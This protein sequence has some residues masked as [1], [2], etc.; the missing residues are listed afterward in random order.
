MPHKSLISIVDDDE[1][2]RE[3]MS[4]LMK[5]LGF[6]AETFASAQSFLGSDRAQSTGCLIADVQMPGMTGIELHSHLCAVGC[7]IPTV[8]ITAYPDDATRTRARKAGIIGYLTKPFRVDDLLQCIRTALGQNKQ[9][10]TAH[11]A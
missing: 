6:S 10:T 11:D 5:S 8:L 9:R 7:E 3:A 2:V 4:G 1:S